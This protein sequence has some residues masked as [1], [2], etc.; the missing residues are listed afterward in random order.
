MNSGKF[1]T[2]F[3]IALLTLALALGVFIAAPYL[4]D[5]LLALAFAIIFKPVHK[6]ILAVMPGREGLAAFLGMVLALFVVFLPLIFF[7][8]QVLNEAAGLYAALG[9][10]GGDSNVLK[11]ADN[12]IEEKLLR[13]LSEFLPGVV[14]SDISLAEINAA[15]YLEQF[16]AWIVENIGTLFSGIA[17]ITIGLLLSAMALYYLFKDGHRLRDAVLE[18]LPFSADDNRKIFEKLEVTAESVI[19]GTLV[20][21]AVQGVLAGLGFLLFGVPSPVLWGSV[22]AVAS[23]LPAV[24]TAVI[25]VPAALYLIFSG[26]L[27]QGIG[28]LVWGSFIVGLVDNF[29]RP[30]LI[31]RGVHI[32][33]FL[34]LLSVL[35]GFGLFGA[36]GFLLGPLVLSLI[37]ALLEMYPVLLLGRAR[38]GNR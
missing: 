6:K 11:V 4:G 27:V 38:E 36:L 30:Y 35:G 15:P 26:S 17:R 29:I 20:V 3:F 18:L 14:P 13:R 23:L 1:E 31:K 21:A 16:L 2:Q 19:K 7:G 32:H 33:P 9:R 24:G 34:I 28:L 22:S 10:G 37:F 25:V 5:I 8:F 12:V